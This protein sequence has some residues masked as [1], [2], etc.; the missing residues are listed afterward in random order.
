MKIKLEDIKI[1]KEFE[2]HPP[3]ETKMFNKL[4]YYAKNH[5]FESDIVINEK[6]V[7]I[8]GYTTYLLAQKLEF[9]KVKVRIR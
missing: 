9:K 7:L 2:V 4:L 5:K 6:N 3:R 8:D 1:S